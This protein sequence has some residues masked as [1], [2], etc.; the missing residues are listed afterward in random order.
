MNSLLEDGPIS[1]MGV[2]GRKDF[3]NFRRRAPDKQDK[4]ASS[5][6]DI[7]IVF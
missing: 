2:L 6:S 1:G 7:D 4:Q 3:R 5:F